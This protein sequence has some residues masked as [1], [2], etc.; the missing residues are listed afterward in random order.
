M[1]EFLYNKG[2]KYRLIKTL[3]K[4][5][6]SY[7]DIFGNVMVYDMFESIGYCGV[8]VTSSRNSS[9]CKGANDECKENWITFYLKEYLYF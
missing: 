9:K 8:K 6:K 1:V 4:F 2:H 3:F 7:V 5:R